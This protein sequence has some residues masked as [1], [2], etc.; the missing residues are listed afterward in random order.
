MTMAR[1]LSIKLDV[2]MP[3]FPGETKKQAEDRLVEMFKDDIDALVSW[4]AENSVVEED[5]TDYE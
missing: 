5:E 4:D 1:Y 2:Y 3:M